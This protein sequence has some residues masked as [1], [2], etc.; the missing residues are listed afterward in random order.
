MIIEIFLNKFFHKN[1]NQKTRIISS[2]LKEYIRE[3]KD[4][5]VLMET[6]NDE[7]NIRITVF[8]YWKSIKYKNVSYPAL[9][10][11]MS[12]ADF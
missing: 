6:F 8:W 4:L 9:V 12:Q 7:F 5:Y 10:I 2:P 11:T 3:E 1:Q